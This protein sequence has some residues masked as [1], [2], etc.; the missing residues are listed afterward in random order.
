MID[1]HC[2]LLPGLDDGPETLEQSLAMAEAAIADGTTHV[3]ATPHA[4]HRYVFDYPRVRALRDELA[5]ALGDRLHVATGCDF[6]MSFE[7]LQAVREQ[8]EPFTINQ[9]N[10]LLVEFA[11]FSIPASL[12]DALHQLQ[13]AGLNPVITHPERNGLLVANP[14]RLEQWVSRGCYVQVTAGSLLGRFG[15]AAQRA[16]EEWLDHGLVHF[17]A[18]DAHNTSSRPPRLSEAHDF[19]AQSRGEDVARA[20]FRENPLAAIEGRPLPWTPEPAELAGAGRASRPRK[21]FLFF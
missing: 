8:P 6:H 19:V 9:K 21:R 5:A 12:D 1:I 3:V 4:S 15:P 20:L 13:L 2:H 17:V 7:N 11:D 10:Y 18:S 14:Q 16:A